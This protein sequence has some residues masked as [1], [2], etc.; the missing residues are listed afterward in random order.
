MLLFLSFKVNE[1][2]RPFFADQFSESAVSTLV[3]LLFFVKN[4]HVAFPRNVVVSLYFHRYCFGLF[5]MEARE[6]F[7]GMLIFLW[8]S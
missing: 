6:V 4:D 3:L 5:A 1:L 8:C 7:E 2:L